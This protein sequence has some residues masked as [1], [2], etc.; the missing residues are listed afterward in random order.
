MVLRVAGLLFVAAPETRSES[1][2]R[3]SGWLAVDVTWTLLQEGILAERR[4]APDLA[5]Q[6]LLEALD[7]AGRV[8]DVLLA[9]EKRMAVRADVHAQLFAG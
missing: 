7:L 8:D 5:L 1:K 2:R 6:S 3:A 9:G 4:L